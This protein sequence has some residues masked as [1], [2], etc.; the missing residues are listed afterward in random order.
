MNSAIHDHQLVEDC[1]KGQ[2]RAQHELYKRYGPLTFGICRRYAKD[3]MEAEDL[4]QLGWIRTFDKLKSFQNTGPLGAWLRSLFVNVC[5]NAFKK[6]KS[7]LQWLS[8]GLENENTLE[9][10]DPNPPSDFLELERLTRLISELPNGPRL[11]FNLFAIEGMNHKEIAEN[12]NISEETSRTQL[13]RARLA[14]MENLSVD[15][16]RTKSQFPE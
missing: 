7:E 6:R 8:I 15:S 11:V 13:R 5:L 3:L 12:L 14:L 16:N 10:S 2:S 4:H 1:L 9:V